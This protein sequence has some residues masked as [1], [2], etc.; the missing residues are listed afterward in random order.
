LRARSLEMTWK[1][2]ALYRGLPPRLN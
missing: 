2:L 1:G